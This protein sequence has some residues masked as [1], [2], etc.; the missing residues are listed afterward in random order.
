MRNAEK[1]GL[2]NHFIYLIGDPKRAF[3]KIGISKNVKRRMAE[4]NVPFELVLHASVRVMSEG[5]AR[6]VEF[7]LHQHFKDHHQHVKGEWFKKISATE[8]RRVARQEIEDAV[9]LNERIGV[10]F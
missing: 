6:Y 7:R 1:K 10:E 4:L 5:M 9:V 3:C 8:F 2:M